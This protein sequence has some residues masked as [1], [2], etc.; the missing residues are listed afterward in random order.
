MTNI[1]DKEPIKTVQELTGHPYQLELFRHTG[2]PYTNAFEF[3]ESI[4]RFIVG[5]DRARYMKP[6]GSIGSVKRNKDGTALP[7]EKI[8]EHKGTAYTLE[9]KPT[10][11][12]QKNGQYKALFPGIREEIIEFVIFKLAIEEGYFYDGE[13]GD[14]TKTDN[15]TVFTTIYKIQQE[16]KK[17]SG[18]NNPSYNYQQIIEALTILK[19]TNYSLMGKGKDDSYKFSPFVEFG[20]VAKG[21]GKTARG[22]NAT[23]YIKLNSLVAKSIISKNWRQISYL[24]ILTDDSYLGRWFRKT[25][26]LR[27]TYASLGKKFNIKLSTIINKSGIT[28]YKRTQDSLKLIVKTLDELDI[29][30]RIN[31]SKEYK[32]NPKTRRKVLSDALIDIYPSSEFVKATIASNAHTKRLSRA[33]E[34]KDGSMLLEPRRGDFKTI[35]EYEKVRREYLNQQVLELK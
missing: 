14:N 11:V 28:P 18:T 27:F 2:I 21:E 29:V 23:I 12:K 20:H 1:D 16:L 32:M 34:G 15:Y 3:Y 5:G 30:E 4:P 9:I 13:G 17:R 25:L 35:Q 6:D 19:E 7:I 22:K 31:V 8:Y 24:D 10:S 33:L 26:A